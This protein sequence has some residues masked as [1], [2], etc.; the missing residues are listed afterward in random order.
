MQD[1]LRSVVTN[2]GQL[3]YDR[4]KGTFRGWLFTATRNKIFNF[5]E[6][7]R[8]QTRGS[9]DAS[10]HHR[11][12]EV[13]AREEDQDDWDREY[14]QRCFAWAADRIQSE[15]QDSTWQA[16]WLTA[17]DGL[18]AKVAGAQLKMSAGAVY[19]AKSRVIARL[20]EE[21]DTLTNE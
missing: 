10:A 15:F 1:V 8:R 18:S 19:V 9:G 16:F 11:L 20:R 13:P 4:A 12:E 5:F 14:E 21:I 17:V 3:H 7:Q 2:A 6:K